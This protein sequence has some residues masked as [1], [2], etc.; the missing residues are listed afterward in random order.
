MKQ[1]KLREKFKKTSTLLARYNE[2]I[3]AL[4]K[5]KDLTPED[6]ET[7][8]NQA[9]TVENKTKDL[10][11]AEADFQEQTRILNE[12]EAQHKRLEQKN[13]THDAELLKITKLQEKA[14][15]VIQKKK[16]QELNQAT[17][18]LLFKWGTVGFVGLVIALIFILIS[19]PG[20]PTLLIVIMGVVITI[21]PGVEVVF[22]IRM[23]RFHG[24][25]AEILRL[26]LDEGI[27]AENH[28]LDAIFEQGRQRLLTLD[29]EKQE[30]MV[31][32]EK[33]QTASTKKESARQL[34]DSCRAMIS[35]ATSMIQQIQERM[36]QPTLKA[37][38]DGLE[39]KTKLTAELNATKVSLEEIFP[40]A[41]IAE[42]KWAAE[43]KTLEDFKDKAVGTEY[44]EEKEHELL[45]N[46]TKFNDLKAEI[47]K[48]LLAARAQLD[49]IN[50]TFQTLFPNA[51]QACPSIAA[52]TA[53]I[54]IYEQARQAVKEQYHSGLKAVEI[55]EEILKEEQE[56]I[57]Q[58]V[59]STNAAKYYSAITQTPWKSVN[60][61]TAESTI[62]LEPETGLPLK[63]EQLS[64]GSQD[65]IYFCIRIG[66]MEKLLDGEPGILIL[67]EAFL[68]SDPDRLSQQ[69][70]I[71]EDFVRLGWQIFYFTAKSEIKHWAEGR[72][73]INFVNMI[74][75]N[76]FGSEQ[77]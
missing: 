42:D 20:A 36:G 30:Y 73:G 10:A 26:Y 58:L 43:L 46:H 61:N 74:P 62:V 31:I 8:Q 3:Q 1:A 6:C 15:D 2:K 4:E 52:L 59:A 76:S 55:L 51:S 14:S 28:N 7:W 53:L 19:D 50:E 54:P 9:N 5:L 48:K 22:I 72:V 12:N 64:A 67:D 27:S 70:Q 68:R 32:H 16:E 56:K 35:D 47:S 18:N 57:G 65:Q 75:N 29:K 66:L 39:Q 25:E 41:S 45:H 49:T 11:N 17:S 63:I 34:T 24:M 23:K 38:K 13:A 44:L 71:L 77:A 21:I 60:W 33:F 69:M 40:P 37:F